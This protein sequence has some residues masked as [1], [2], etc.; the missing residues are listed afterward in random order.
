MRGSDLKIDAVVIRDAEGERRLTLNDLPLRLGTGSDC[1][2][3][4]PGP[5]SQ[6]AASLDVLDDQPF[7]QPVGRGGVVSVN[8]E[9]LTASLRLH[10]GDELGY[11]GTRIVVTGTDGAM[12]LEVRLEDSAYVTKPPELADDA[13][14]TEETIAPTAFQRAAKVA[15][16]EKPPRAH[17]WQAMVGAAIAMLAIL[18][19]LLFTAR[20]I[21]FEVEPVAA[22][23]LEIS[24]GWFRLSLADRV[25]LREGSHTVHVKAEGYYDMDQSFRVDERPSRT[26]LVELR[27]LP[28]FLTVVTAPPVSAL[29]TVDDVTVGQAPFGPIELE[30]GTHSITVSAERYLPFADNLVVPGL[31]RTQIVE[32]QLVPRW[33]NI[34]ISSDPSGATVREGKKDLGTTPLQIELSEGSHDLTVVHD[35][36]SPWDS[37]IEVRANEDR[38]LPL[39]KLLPADARLTVNSIPRGANVTVNGRYRGQ[40]PLKLDLSPDIDYRIGLSKA[41][42]GSTER[43]V[44][45]R[46]AASE[47]I[48]VDLSARVGKLTVSASPADALIFIDG[49]ERGSG[50]RTFSLSS[51][52]H[53]LEVR[54]SGYESFKRSV[55]TRPGYPQTIQVR[56]LSDEEARL[57][58]VSSTMTNSTGQELRRVEPGTF[59]MGAS[60]REQ[61]R[62][63]NEVLVPVKLTKPYFIGAREVTNREYL[64]FRGNHVSD[65]GVHASLAANTNPVVNVSWADAVEYCN[66]LSAEEGLT[67]AYAKQFEKWESV[68]PT[69]NG[70]R[71][72]TEAEWVWAIRFQARSSA[73]TFPWGN[74]L[75]PRRDSGNYAGYS[76]R[77]LVPSVLPG[78]DDG[79]ASTS[80]VGS[81]A[82]NALGIYDGSGNVAEWTQDYYTVPQPGI[83][84]ALTDPTGPKRGTQRVIRGSSWRHAGV[85]ELRSSYREFGTNG[86]VD[87]GFRIARNVK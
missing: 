46:A 47:S 22:D 55:T 70:Y 24:G 75:P 17:R 76:A 82:A 53:V 15:V 45:L 73:P 67:P 81:F 11:F 7:L 71:L 39:I 23:T 50:S 32:V 36:F 3:R 33:A 59:T 79:F 72:P 43:Q 58:S 49:R 27:K 44:R 25:L 68:L 6:A 14:L 29:V 84:E 60:R 16:S 21:R 74:R 37:V 62:R 10:E 4:L 56:L 18:S 34:D 12:L 5:G 80:P 51:A 28:G 30:P 20:S 2:L 78:Y 38:S 13:L 48:T 66:W 86:R 83:T 26:I 41:G 31:G 35:G 65:N 1:E 61:G 64:R 77:D 63:A 9:P 87:V 40:S 8:G 54:K 57:R 69:P 52:P 42:Y 19:Y 85:T